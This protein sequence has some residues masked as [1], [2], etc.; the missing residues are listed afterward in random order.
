MIL[1][2]CIINCIFVIYYNHNIICFCKFRLPDQKSSIKF[3]YL[4]LIIHQLINKP[5]YLI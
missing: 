2:L 3:L 4:R 5:L 1:T